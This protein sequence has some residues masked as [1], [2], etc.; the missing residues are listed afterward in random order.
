MPITYTRD[1][2]DAP[3]NPSVDQGPMKTNTN[4]IDSIIAVD[5]YTFA[6]IPSGTH[7]QVTI[8]GKNAAGAQTDPASAIYTASGTASTVAQL[9]YRNQDGIFPLS[10]VRAWVS[11]AGTAAV[12]VIVPIQSVNIATVNKSATGTYQ[13]TPTANAL[14]GTSLAVFV[15]VSRNPGNPTI[16]VVTN[17][18]VSA[19]PVIDIKTTISPNSDIDCSLVS[20]MI[21]Q[22]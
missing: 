16:A 12:G 6:D 19:G 1:I 17:Y 10:C 13:I 9:T 18:S 2:P 22:I 21:V 4:S 7:K 3:N 15:S 20:V 8:S 11:F 5:H 14:T